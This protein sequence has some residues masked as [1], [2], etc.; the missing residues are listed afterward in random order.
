M[1]DR[2][3]GSLHHEWTLLPQSYISLP[4]QLEV[5]IIKTMSDTNI[6]INIKKIECILN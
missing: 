3:D 5:F 6:A 1:K 2:S 4:D